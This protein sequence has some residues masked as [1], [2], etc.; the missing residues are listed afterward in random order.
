MKMFKPAVS[1]LIIAAILFACQKEDSG[2]NQSNETKLVADKTT[3]K[4]GESISLTVQNKTQGSV[5]RWTVTPTLG[6]VI[7]SAYS[8]QSNKITFSQAGNYTIKAELRTVHPNCMPSPG[9][10][11]CYVNGSAAGL[12]SGSIVVSN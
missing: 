11:T 1:L 12:L 10:D 8:R 3:I 7:D 4:T 6:V 2:N 5:A 9:Y